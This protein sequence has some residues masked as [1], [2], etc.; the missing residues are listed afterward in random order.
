[1]PST[2]RPRPRSREPFLNIAEGRL[3]R[4]RVWSEERWR[5]LPD[6]RRLRT[7]VHVPG[8]G[9]VGA[10]PVPRARG[11]LTDS[12]GAVRRRADRPCV[13]AWGR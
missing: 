10:V 9:R 6:D 8:L 1:M 3:C 2:S 5:A 13:T 7:C 12:I 4:L 11:P